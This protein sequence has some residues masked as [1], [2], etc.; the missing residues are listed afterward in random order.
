MKQERLIRLPEVEH[1]TS[2]S[3][4]YIYEEMKTGNFPA[5]VSTG[6]RTVAWVESEI[7]AWIQNKVIEARLGK[8]HQH[9]GLIA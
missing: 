4:S 8:D 3:Q 7:Q 5:N 9:G 6:P 2:K 1:Q